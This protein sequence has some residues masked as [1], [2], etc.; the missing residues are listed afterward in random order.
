VPLGHGLR[1]ALT[2]NAASVDRDFR[3]SAEV[4]R[5]FLKLLRRRG[6]VGSTLRMMH[7]VGFLGRYLPE[8][9]RISLLIQHDLYHHYTVDEHTLKVVEALDELHNSKDR[10]RAQLRAVLDEVADVA[11]LYLALLL[12]DIGKGREGGHVA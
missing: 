12:H 2:R 11:L 3:D 8:F 6:R 10:R 1:E 7:E 4:A 9:A 5:S